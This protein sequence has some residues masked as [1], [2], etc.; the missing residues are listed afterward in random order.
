MA[1]CDI[2]NIQ[3]PSRKLMASGDHDADSAADVL[4]IFAQ[5]AFEDGAPFQFETPSGPVIHEVPDRSTY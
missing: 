1:N 3:Q 4:Q 2:H 5:S